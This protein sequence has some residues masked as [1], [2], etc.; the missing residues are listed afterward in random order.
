MC[1]KIGLDKYENDDF[2]VLTIALVQS[3]VQ[4]IRGKGSKQVI[5]RPYL[6]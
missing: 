4:Y 5:I 6:W 3:K 1:E 2:I